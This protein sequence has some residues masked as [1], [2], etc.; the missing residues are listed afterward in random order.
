MYRCLNVFIQQFE[1]ILFF[2]PKFM[3]ESF[4]FFME[5]AAKWKR[6]ERKTRTTTTAREQKA[7]AIFSIGFERDSHWMCV[8]ASV[9]WPCK[10]KKT[11]TYVIVDREFTS[12]SV[13]LNLVNDLQWK[14]IWNG[15]ALACSVIVWFGV[16]VCVVRGFALLLPCSC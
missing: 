11:K 5:K 2:S 1:V 10:Q 16:W 15:V 13:P 7:N 4:G 9:F 6:D 12:K 8:W 3:Y 14:P